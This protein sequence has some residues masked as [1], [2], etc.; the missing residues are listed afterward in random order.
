MSGDIPC[1]MNY[2]ELLN[3]DGSIIAKYCPLVSKTLYIM[4]CIFIQAVQYI[5]I[6]FDFIKKYFR[7]ILQ[8]EVVI[9]T[10]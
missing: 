9:V 8:I 2:V 3:R 5:R 4:S 10:M 6:L 1:E 7:V